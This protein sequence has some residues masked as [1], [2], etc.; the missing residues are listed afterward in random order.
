MSP[1]RV[2]D[3]SGEAVVGS[4]FCWPGWFGAADTLVL[5][6][7]GDGLVKD[8]RLEL[9]A[10]LFVGPADADL[11]GAVKEVFWHLVRRE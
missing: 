4:W 1:H 8:G 2:K 3:W 7:V 5:E 11:D 9:S 10:E 6:D